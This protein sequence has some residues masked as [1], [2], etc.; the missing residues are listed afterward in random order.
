LTLPFG[1]PRSMLNVPVGGARRCAAES[2][3]LDRVKTVKDAAGVSLSDVVLAM[4]AGA[5]R[6]FV[7][8][9]DAL[10]DTPLVAMVPVSLRSDGDSVGG[11]MV[12]AVLC[13][14][15]TH[16][17]DPARRLDAIHSSM[18]NNKKVLSALPRVQAMA[19]SMVLLSPA[20]LSTL[21]GLAKA[22]PPAF[23]LC[24]SN[25]AGSREPLY[26]NGARLAGNYPMSL[27]LDGQALNIT[28]TGNADTVDFGLVGCRRSVP[29]L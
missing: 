4:C 19:L 21:P 2:W 1:A 10:P 22:T 17:D 8:D 28:L 7:D 9:N 13:N 16:L 20:A 24:I 26:F 29:H 23:N 12:G 27:V 5:L 3:P 18:R 14:L 15:A 6:A 11:N 25:V